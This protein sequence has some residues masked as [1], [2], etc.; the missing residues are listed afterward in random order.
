MVKDKTIERYNFFSTNSQER[1]LR[2]IT[3]A[4]LQNIN[5]KIAHSLK[6]GK[7]T[8][9]VACN[10]LAIFEHISLYYKSDSQT[11]K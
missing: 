2:T 3:N 7:K 8:Y 6:E 4:V 9:D 11:S 10:P 1:S 5:N